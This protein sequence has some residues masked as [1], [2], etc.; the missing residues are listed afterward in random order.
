MRRLLIGASCVLLILV[1]VSFVW[2]SARS[3]KHSTLRISAGS[4]KGL[5]HQIAR[6]L[7]Q[8]T[9]RKG[10][11]LKVVPTIGSGDALRRVNDGSLDFALTQ[12]G[13]SYDSYANIRQVAVL[14]IEPLHLL[15]KIPNDEIDDRGHLTLFDLAD[16][17]KG[18]PDLS[19][20]VSK[21]GSG[22]N[23]LATGVLD[24][25]GLQAGA[26]YHASRLSYTEL[27][28]PSREAVDLPDAVFTV[29]S[30][31]SPV[32]HYLIGNHSYLP[33]ELPVA[34]AF[35]IDWSPERAS[36]KSETIIRRRIVETTI[37]AF[38][39]QV[40]PPVPA[41]PIR[42]IG[43]RLH[44][45]AHVD[46]P[47]VAVE[48]VVDSIYDS[49]FANA[50]N[51]PLTVDLLQSAAEYDLHA[52]AANYLRK[53]TPIIT[54][55]AVELTEQVLAILGSIF[56]AVLF[57]W[58]GQLFIRRRRRDRQFLQCIERVGQIEQRAMAFESDPSMSVDDLVELQ[59]ELN[60]I[61]V[62][63][64]AQFQQGDIDG[65]DTLSGFLM[66]VNDAN[67]NLTRT[68]LHE[69]SPKLKY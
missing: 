61:K 64:I 33:V 54:E 59:G 21:T 48:R 8:V 29:S 1:V 16:R 3:P 56:A 19:I 32:A 52:G 57:V 47:D 43:T 40:N 45:V 5:R 35:R 60:R 20:N 7:G 65:A 50:S 14:H 31:P 2:V 63:I 39:Y 36:K 62:D 26:D 68:I 25:F 24:F 9:E 23:V 10:V 69:R 4:A 13:L 58:Q 12:G 44:L 6:S 28:D 22:T 66:H 38:T 27:L 11:E 49:S 41:D 53:K 55:H 34:D 42:T 17:W 18:K 51:P 37:P 46:T 67:E 30:L 15:V